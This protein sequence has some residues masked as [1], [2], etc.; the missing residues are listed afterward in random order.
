MVLQSAPEQVKEE[1]VASRRLEMFGII[2]CLHLLCSPGGVTEKQVLL[3]T[4][5][6]PAEVSVLS[7]APGA[8]RRW[9]RWKART[10]EIGATPPDQTLLLKGLNRLVRKVVEP[11]RELQ[12]RVSLVRSSLSVDTKLQ[13]ISKLHS[14]LT[15]CFRSWKKL[16]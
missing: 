12:F 1:L 8:L 7:E 5:E 2:T 3:K 11:N 16:R 6:D 10:L 13:V 15:T 9:L 4:F 14:L